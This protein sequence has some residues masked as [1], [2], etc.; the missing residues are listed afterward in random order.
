[1]TKKLKFEPTSDEAQSLFEQPRP[2]AEYLPTWYRDMPLHLPGEKTTGLSPDGVAVSNLTLKG[3]MPFLDAMTSGYMFV[4]PFDMDLRRN[5][6]GMIGLRWATNINFVG[7]HGPDQAPGLP[8]PFGA[9]PSILKWSPGWRVITPPGY[10]CLY[11][12]PLNHF[13][14][15]FATL[16]GVVDT[17][18]Y[19]L[20][21]EFPF[22]LL[23]IKK[24][25]VI[26]EKGTPICQVIPFKR[27]D[28]SS[29]AVDFDEEAMKRNGFMLKSK[30]IRSYQLQFWK[31]KSYK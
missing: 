1:M 6:K 15:P 13:D 5:E 11:T 30:I 22:R 21:V 24:D 14:L 23:D 8:M 18:S 19:N 3:C 29:T 20:G 12:H 2:A 4:L 25:V 16:S 27:D 17:D 7:Q 28:W 26:L 9:S 10:S 31:K